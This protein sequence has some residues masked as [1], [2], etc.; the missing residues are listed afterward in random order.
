MI[1]IA[2]ATGFVGRHLMKALKEVG[3]DVRCLLRSESNAD[4][5]S[6]V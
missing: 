2:G 1:F 6:V 4:R 3:M 5:K